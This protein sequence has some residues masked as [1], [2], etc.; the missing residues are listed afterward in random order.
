MEDTIIAIPAGSPLDEELDR[1]AS[2]TGHTKADVALEV[3]IEWLEDQADV[4]SAQEVVDRN[5]PTTS[6]AEMRREFGLAR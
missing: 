6:L 2:A 1:V 4:V 5:E 3:L